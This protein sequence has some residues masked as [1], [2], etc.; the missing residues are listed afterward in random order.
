MLPAV[1]PDGVPAV[2]TIVSA[3]V[4]AMAVDVV[5]G[6]LVIGAISSCRPENADFPAMLE[7]TLRNKAVK[8]LRARIGDFC[9]V[10]TYIPQGKAIDHADY[11]YKHR[12]LDRLKA[13]FEREYDEDEKVVW[14]GD[15]NVAPTDIDVTSPEKKRDH[16]CFAPDIQE[17]FEDVKSWGFVDLLRK[18]RP[19]PGEF[20]Y[21]DYRVKNAME[22][23]IG[24]RID[25]ILVTP[26]LEK[27]AADCYIDRAPRGWERPSDHTPVVAVFDL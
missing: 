4:G 10:N 2:L 26:A 27:L 8:G 13:M 11:Q 22:R 17:H 24:W 19:G 9:M 25:H 7:R 18:Y 16:P 6:G 23:N 1:A 5:S 21:F 14:L 20:S 3:G 12:F 15:M